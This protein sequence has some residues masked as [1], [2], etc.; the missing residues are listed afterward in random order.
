MTIPRRLAPLPLIPW[1]VRAHSDSNDLTGAIADGLI[2]LERD[3]SA[4]NAGVISGVARVGETL[5]TPIPEFSDIHAL[6]HATFTCLRR[7]DETADPGIPD[8]T[9]ATLSRSDEGDVTSLNARV[10]LPD[11]RNHQETLT[12]EPTD[13]VAA[14][15]TSFTATFSNVPTSHSDGGTGCAAPIRTHRSACMTHLPDQ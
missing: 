1:A 10:P 4:R 11:L 15:P 14:T 3:G 7:S 6:H 5:T 2:P 12:S 8:A 13:T 9:G